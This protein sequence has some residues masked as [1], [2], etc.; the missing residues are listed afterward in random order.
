MA[1]TSGNRKTN[2][3]RSH[4]PD[5]RGPREAS[6]QKKRQQLEWRL[7]Q[8]R[9]RHRKGTFTHKNLKELEGLAK[10]EV[11]V[12]AHELFGEAKH[13]IDKIRESMT[14]VEA[15]IVHKKARKAA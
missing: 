9:E 4:T 6:P 7:A 12:L 8:L 13:A 10:T 3:G 5:K 15:E 11:I 2:G 1:A 14:A